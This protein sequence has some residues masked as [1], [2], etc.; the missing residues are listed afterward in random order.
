MGFSLFPYLFMY[1]AALG[2]LA[3]Y[4]MYIVACRWSSWGRRAPGHMGSVAAARRLSLVALHHA[5]LSSPIR[6]RA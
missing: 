3:S 5:D 2:L 4:G 1:V 6:D